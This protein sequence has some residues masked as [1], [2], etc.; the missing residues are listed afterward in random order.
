M[1]GDEMRAAAERIADRLFTSGVGHTAD[2]LVLFM[3]DALGGKNRDLGGWS[4]KAVVEQ[5]VSALSQDDERI[6]AEWL[7]SIGSREP[8][9][10]DDA[11]PPTMT[12]PGYRYGV[13]VQHSEREWVWCRGP[14]VLATVCTRG[15]LRRLMAAIGAKPGN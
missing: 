11:A 14:H 3:E 15:H 4:R 8:H 10:L 6:T 13:L 7:R 1:S 12:I 2:R 5:V 9:D